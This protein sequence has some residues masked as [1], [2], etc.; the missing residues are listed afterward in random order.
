MRKFCF[1]IILFILLPLIYFSSC[2]KGDDW[3]EERPVISDIRFN[4]SDTLMYGPSAAEKTVILINDSSVM[5]RT[6]DTAI[7]SRWLYI[8]AHFSG[9]NDLSSF[10]VGGILTYKT[11]AGLEIKDTIM[12]LGQSIFNKKDTLVYKNKLIQIP[13]SL[14]RTIDGVSHRGGLQEGEYKLSIL[15]MDKA[16]KKSDSILHSVTI[17]RRATILAARQKPVEEI[18]QE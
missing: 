14:D 6:M 5:N 17:L 10:K 12:R 1:A 3:S 18:P 4:E 13:D 9:S 15:C 2:E 8:T 16:G 11:K 7:V